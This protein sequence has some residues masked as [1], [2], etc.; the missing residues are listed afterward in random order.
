MRKFQTH[1]WR[2]DPMNPILPPGAPHPAAY[3]STA[4]MNPFVVIQGDEYYLFYAGG[5]N[6]GNRRICLAIAH[7]D[8]LS[9]WNR[10]GPVLDLGGPT[11]FDSLWCV[12]PC[13]HRINGKWHLYYTGRDATKLH[14]GLQGFW[15]MGLAVSDDLRNWRRISSDPIMTGA[16]FDEFPHNRA[17]AGGGTIQEITDD[18]GRLLYRMHFTLPTGTPSPDLLVDQAKHAA[19]AHSYDGI[20]WF[21][22]RI[23]LRP[24]LSADYENAACIALNVW[25][26]PTRW[27]AIYAGIGS[28]FGAYSICEA[29]SDDGLNWERGL[30]GEN[31]ALP[32]TGGEGWESQ[33]TEYPHIVREGNTLRLFYCGNGYGR[34]GIGTAVADMLD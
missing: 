8:N 11:D 34:T 27:R 32:P 7:K 28:R 9:Q 26:T 1:Q 4:C 14:E 20:Q 18:A 24:R 31:L 12:L 29:V 17:I 13:I 25:K 3:D 6:Q 15:G 10:L 16:G 22:R 23:I 33:M 5:D 2:K 19:I 30:P 21:D